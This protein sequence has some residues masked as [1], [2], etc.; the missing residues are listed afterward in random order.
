[1]KIMFWVSVCVITYTYV[2]YP[3]WLY[4]GSRLFAKPIHAAAYFPTVSVIM[5]VR[6]EADVLPRKLQNLLALQ[7]PAGQMEIIVV[8]DGSTDATKQVLSTFTSDSLR[9]IIQVRHEGKASALNQAIREARGE[10]VVF[11]DA[12]QM[13]EP[14]ALK[15]LMAKFA[16]PSVGGVTGELI[17]DKSAAGKS[18][19]G[20]GLYWKL[21][22]KI[23][24][25]EASIGS[26]VGA[27]GA[28]YAVRRNLL[29][30]LPAGVILDDVYLPLQVVRQGYRMAF[31]SQAVA[32]ESLQSSAA[33]EFRRKVRTLTGNYQLLQ[34]APWLLT[35]SNPLR[36][37]FVSHKLLRLLAPFALGSALLCAF[38]IPEG[39]YRLAAALQLFVYGSGVLAL[40]RPKLRPFGP[41]PDAAFA[42]VLMNTA[43]IVALVN[44]V[45]GRKPVWV[46]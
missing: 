17:L 32:R 15:H 23:R 5:A 11:T 7:Y 1:M 27:T 16:D 33:Q 14:G 20:V 36:F 40:V 35:R 28:F 41:L 8:S 37:Q 12:R 26:V 45:T 22:K 3:L 10:I 2:G 39:F 44:F 31:E 13:I 21:E 42:F 46:R 25:W 34:L 19:E 18:L 43:A 38:L 6:N 29:V 4:V 24:Q 9:A 30:T